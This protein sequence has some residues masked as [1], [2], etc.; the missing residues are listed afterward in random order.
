MNVHC[1]KRAKKI[2]LVTSNRLPE[3][4]LDKVFQVFD[5]LKE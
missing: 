3:S 5:Y 4:K 1:K 2:Y